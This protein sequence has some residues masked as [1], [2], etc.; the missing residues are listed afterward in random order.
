MMYKLCE[1]GKHVPVTLDFCLDC[2]ETMGDIKNHKIFPVH[3]RSTRR[4]K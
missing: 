2:S 4:K 1:C 3:I